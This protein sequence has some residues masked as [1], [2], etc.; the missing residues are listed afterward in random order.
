MMF[1]RCTVKTLS[2]NHA[3]CRVLLSTA[4]LF[5]VQ[6]TVAQPPITEPHPLSDEA[7]QLLERIKTKVTEY[8]AQFKSG[9]VEFSITLS[10][11]IPQSTNLF[12]DFLGWLQ[13]KEKIPL[14]EDKAV[15]HIIYRFDREREF[16]DVKARKKTE[17]NGRPLRDWQETHYQYLI[18]GKTLHIRKRTDSSKAS[19][20]FEN[21]FNPHWW[22]W[23]P[24]GLTFGRFIRGYDPIDVKTVKTDNTRYYYLRLYRKMQQGSD[25][26][27]TREIW[28]HPQKDYHA[29][30]IMQY[31]RLA[32][33]IDRQGT[34]REAFFLTR[35]TY[36]LTQYEPGIWFPKTVTQEHFDGGLME[37]ILPNT[38]EAEYPVIMSEALIPQSFREEKL[39]W[40]WRKV[41]VQVHR[42]AFNI[43][44][45]EE[46]LRFSD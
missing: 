46:D 36:Q 14:Y 1:F 41:T 32:T 5:I 10:Q 26:A 15:W 44:I 13:K 27:W 6:P 21:E 31:G 34:L 25:K 19:Q 33:E 40:P 43:P 42:A 9:E 38:P 16:Y 20:H 18:D 4:L 30:R 37:E 8:N 23:P 22:G 2:V 39:T 3:F 28:M 29:I 11:K 45:A 12:K 24:E 35:K 7:A 17:L